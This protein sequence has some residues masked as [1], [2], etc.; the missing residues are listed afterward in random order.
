[1]F[2]FCYCGQ[3]QMATG[4]NIATPSN[5][6]CRTIFLWA[7]LPVQSLW[8]GQKA[9][10]VKE[11][12]KHSKIESGVGRLPRKKTGLYIHDLSIILWSRLRWEALE[13]SWHPGV[14]LCCYAA[15]MI[16]FYIFLHF[17]N[18]LF[19]IF[20]KKFCLRSLSVSGFFC[21][22]LLLSSRF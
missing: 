16:L 7:V 11:T 5:I 9:G 12:N 2:S 15:A 18:Q 21:S 8:C 1:M 17:C 3:V 6:E 10:I 19:K 20:S 22:F 14:L 4:K 13:I